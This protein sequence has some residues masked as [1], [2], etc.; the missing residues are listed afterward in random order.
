[1]AFIWSDEL[2]TQVAELYAE[3]IG[4]IEEDKQA[5]ASSEIVA[6][7]RD[8]LKRETGEVPT[9]NGIIMI[10]SKAGIYVSQSKKKA[11]SP[12]ASGGR[13]SKQDA[14]DDLKGAIEAFNQEYD[15]EL[16]SKLTAK[17][18]DMFTKILQGIQANM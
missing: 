10:L 8:I 15:E 18:A 5:S 14:H 2:R 9:P 17:A 1:M 16:I 4:A 7:I 3:K 12:S 6:E 11:A 13:R